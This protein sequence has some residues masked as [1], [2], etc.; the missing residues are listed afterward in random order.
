M[1]PRRATATALRVA[2]SIVQTS[3]SRANST[4]DR[5]QSRLFRKTG[6]REG[7]IKTRR[8]DIKSSANTDVHSTA[9]KT[10]PIH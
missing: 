3:G 8:R 2:L 6:R 10:S 1:N 4:K 7:G 9:K 5:R